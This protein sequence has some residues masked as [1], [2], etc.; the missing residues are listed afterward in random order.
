MVVIDIEEHTGSDTAPEP[1]AACRPHDRAH[2]LSAAL[3]RI[4]RFNIRMRAEMTAA[5]F[6]GRE[7]PT[8]VVLHRLAEEGPLRAGA[9][10]DRLYMDP[11]QV[12]RAVAALVRERAVQRL[13]DPD[14]GRATLLVTTPAGRE[15]A[16][17]F[18]RAKSAHVAS[19]IADWDT[20]DAEAFTAGLERFVDG[21]ERVLPARP[22]QQP[23]AHFSPAQCSP[24]QFSPA[25]FSPAQTPPARTGPDGDDAPDTTPAEPAATT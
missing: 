10:A 12:S 24:A 14:D 3:S 9:L 13:A 18:G 2:R 22:G 20:G 17:R 4:L 7:L 25:Q 5:E 19:V 16:Q 6:D 15:L 23:L 8:L 11:S 21:M 1:A